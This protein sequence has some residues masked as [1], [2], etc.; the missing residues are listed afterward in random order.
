MISEAQKSTFLVVGNWKMNGSR[1]SLGQFVNGLPKKAPV[2][3]RRV[4]CLP[5]ILIPFGQETFENHTV[6]I[7]AQTCNAERFGALT[8][9]I[10]A[11][12]LAENGVSW[13]IVGHSE[14]RDGFSETDADVLGKAAAVHRAGMNAIICVGEQQEDRASG[15]HLDVILQ[16]VER[17]L[18]KSAA[19][20]N[21]VIAYEPVWAI[22]SGESASEDQIFEAHAAIDTWLKENARPLPV[23]YG[24]S[25]KPESASNIAKIQHVSGFLVGGASL[26]PSS[27]QGIIKSSVEIVH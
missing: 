12:M 14:R 15:R 11:E 22:G 5:S 8:G 4:V 10:S 25:V 13:V 1:E 9:E 26:D 23:L 2:G 27:F 7:G 16:Q 21:T 17:S 18:P 19:S 3:C 20:E 6:E 24:G